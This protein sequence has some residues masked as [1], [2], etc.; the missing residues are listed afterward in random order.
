M[1]LPVQVALSN[2]FVSG[3]LRICV[4]TSLASPGLSLCL[5]GE[6]ILRF[7]LASALGYQVQLVNV[8]HLHGLLYKVLTDTIRTQIVAPHIVSVTAPAG[9]IADLKAKALL[10]LK[11]NQPVVPEEESKQTARERKHV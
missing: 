4:D 2:I 10:A 8:P 3:V 5:I 9:L 11:E 6:P 1:S 7:D